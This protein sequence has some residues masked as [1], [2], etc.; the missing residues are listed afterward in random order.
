VSRITLASL[1]I[2]ALLVVEGILALWLGKG[3]L[4]LTFPQ[5]QTFIMLVLIFTSQFRVL[6]VRERRFFWT[7]LPGSALLGSTGG[8]IALFFVIGLLG[9]IVSP[10]GL[11]S[12]AFALG[13]SALFTLILDA[14]KRLSFALFRVE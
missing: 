5:L 8:A 9:I 4:G 1:L 11:T 7:S 2:G 3:Y 12:T 6:I 13:F 10:I 14:P